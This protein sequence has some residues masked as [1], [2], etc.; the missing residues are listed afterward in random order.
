[1][2]RSPNPSGPS[3]TANAGHDPLAPALEELLISLA[4]DEF[5]LGFADSEWTGIAP[6]LEEDVAM[7][8]LA[9]DELAHA[10]HFYGLLANLRGEDP[11]HL[12]YD[13]PPEA[14][15][16]CRLLDHPR[17]DWASAVVRRFLYD[18]ADA[19]RL[20]ALAASTYRPLAELVGKVRREEVHHVAHAR[21]WLERLA[22]GGGE[23]R[24]RVERAWAELASDGA[25][26]FTPLDGEGALVA[27]G[28]MAAPMASLA[29]RW[30]EEIAPLVNALGLEVPPLD[31]LPRRGRRDHSP[32]FVGLWESFTSVR[33][34][35]PEAVW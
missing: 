26:V 31:H 1:M 34:L 15:R 17:G 22:R 28:V 32:A 7:S 35:D 14:F 2:G 27:S 21:W 30:R 6:F 5:V 16:H 24:V 25:S 19:I 11:D 10:A 33:R 8:S 29:V 23:A 20:E 12:A 3:T 9:Q 13:R 18:T 4:D